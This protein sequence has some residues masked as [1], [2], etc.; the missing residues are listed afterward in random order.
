MLSM[1]SPDLSLHL[2]AIIG[3]ILGSLV[4]VIIFIISIMIFIITVL[5]PKLCA[6]C[7]SDYYV[8]SSKVLKVCIQLKMYKVNDSM[9]VGIIQ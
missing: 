7:I 6:A 4:I 2:S 8:K 5:L 1:L 9:E 3:I